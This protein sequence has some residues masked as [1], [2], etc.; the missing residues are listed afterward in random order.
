MSHM[1]LQKRTI[2]RKKGEKLDG[3]IHFLLSELI[4]NNICY[5]AKP[6]GAGYQRSPFL[7]ILLSCSGQLSASLA[8]A[9]GEPLFLVVVTLQLCSGKIKEQGVEVIGGNGQQ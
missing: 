2:I 3:V 7:T 4:K 6:D 9:A 5:V 8:S 1:Y